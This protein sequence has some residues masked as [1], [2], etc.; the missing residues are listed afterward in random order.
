M[1]TVVTAL[2]L[3]QKKKEGLRHREVQLEAQIRIPVQRVE[4]TPLN[5]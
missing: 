5:Q 1:F 2:Y 3:R 4:K